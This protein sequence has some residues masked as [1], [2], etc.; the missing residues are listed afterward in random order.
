MSDREEVLTL[1]PPEH[2]ERFRRSI[3]KA[4]ADFRGLPDYQRGALSRFKAVQAGCFWALMVTAAQM[5][6]A[7]TEVRVTETNNTLTFSFRGHVLVQL[8]KVNRRGRA[9]WGRTRRG[10]AFKA[11]VPLPGEPETHWVYI[12][13]MMDPNG[14]RLE[15]IVMAQGKAGDALRWL[16][17][18]VPPAQLTLTPVSAA[19]PP[20]RSRVRPNPDVTAQRFRKLPTE[21]K[22]E[23]DATEGA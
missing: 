19:E 20:K 8:K 6:F 4:E 9:R 18:I 10:A 16:E 13:Y 15:R 21:E 22:K 17:D 5:E 1:V 12:G 23:S 3:R 14:I 11:G 7:G 2:R